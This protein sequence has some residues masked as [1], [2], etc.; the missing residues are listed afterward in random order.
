MTIKTIDTSV[1]TENMIDA[2]RKAEGTGTAILAALEAA[3]AVE[4]EPIYQ[5]AIKYGSVWVYADAT[6]EVYDIVQT[7]RIVYAHPPT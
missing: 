1:L 5:V 4:V 2:F 3:P 6:K 7:K